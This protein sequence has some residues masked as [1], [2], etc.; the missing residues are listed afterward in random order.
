[1]AKASL[2]LPDGT[3]VHIEG[4]A[5][6]IQKII[7]LHRPSGS[8]TP[9][10]KTSTRKI[11]TTSKSTTKSDDTGIDLMSIVNEIKNYKEAEKIE[12]NILDRTSQVD[13]I[14]LPLY[15]LN[16]VNDK[17]KM[18]SGEIAKVLSDLGVNI[19]QPNVALTL[20]GAASKYVIGDK[21]RKRGQV[22]RYKISRRGLQYLRSVIQNEGD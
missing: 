2:K 20:S 6:E 14:L 4:S 19:F 22:V 10:A 11:K 21:V 3:T 7:S 18:T 1:M 12:E 13:R 5:E 16:N 9:A 8:G 15:I 17:L